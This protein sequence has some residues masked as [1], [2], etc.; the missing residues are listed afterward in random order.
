M[1]TNISST[2]HNTEHYREPGIVDQYRRHRAHGLSATEREA[3]ERYFPTRD[4]TVLDIGCGAGRTTLVLDRWGYDVVGVDISEHMVAEA[5]NACSTVPLTV[6]DATQL[7]FG[8]GTFQYVLFSYN[9]IDELFPESDRLAALHEIY[10][11]LEPGGRV[12]FSTRNLWRHYVLYPLSLEQLR[13]ELQFWREYHRQSVDD[14]RYTIETNFGYTSL[15]YY[16]SPIVQLRQL[17]RCGFT[18][19]TVIGSPDR[20]LLSQFL[21]PSL[22]YMAARPSE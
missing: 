17:R 19:I 18:N 2:K 1:P 21:S 8:D 11:V 6:G 15:V 16:S 9:G 5:R 4:A 14:S 20:G 7:P 13:S 10:R 22:H 12:I 3:I